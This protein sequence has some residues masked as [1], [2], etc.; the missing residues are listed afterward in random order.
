VDFPDVNCIAWF[1][2]T[3]SKAFYVQ[4]I[5]RGTRVLKGVI[6][7]LETAEERR[8]AIAASPKSSVLILDPLFVS[9]RIDLCDSY[10]L[11][12]D[13]P[14]VKKKMKA[15]GPPSEEAAAEAERD[16]I[17]ALNKAAKKAERKAARVINPIDWAI[18]IG[19]DK[20]A[21]YEPSAAWE[22]GKPTQGQIDF[23]RRHHVDISKVQYKGLAQKLIGTILAR[24]NL[25]LASVEQL[26]FL[27]R[28]GLG[29]VATPQL[30]RAD[31][32]A[33]IDQTLAERKAN[34]PSAPS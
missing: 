19:D 13:N 26:D 27:K 9:D 32:T 3:L 24:H 15:L 14:E 28:L 10:D 18:S 30:S 34:R 23:L 17:K 29:E 6:D 4:G 7:G 5:Y 33:I 31:A 1:R 8:A 21:T 25:K 22:M 11:F 20:L 16:F 2:A 12:T